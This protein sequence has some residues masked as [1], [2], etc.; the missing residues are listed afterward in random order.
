MN[1]LHVQAL[2]AAKRFKKAEA[3]L[4]DIFQKIED[5]KVFRKMGYSSLF[6][7]GV[8][9]L[10]L[11]EANTYA[12]IQ[13]ARK[14]RDVPALKSARRDGSLS[15]SKAKKIVS[16]I[17]SENQEDWLMKAQSLSK[18]LLEKEVARVNPK[19]AVQESSKYVTECR[20]ELKLGISEELLKNLKRVQDIESQRTR[21]SA[22]LEDA[23]REMTELYLERNDP[24]RKAERARPQLVP[25][26]VEGEGRKRVPAVLKHAIQF[27]DEGQC[28]HLNPDGSRCTQTRWL[29]TH[30]LKP[31]SMGGTNSIS[32]L[33]TLCFHHHRLRHDV[34]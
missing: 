32:N 9:A 26:P 7:Y 8:K 1:P 21:K 25:G 6:D 28:T 33:T 11:S 18:N 27:R 14:S 34:S 10:R 4:I 12:F 17:T 13:V 19:T 29:E 5:A 24:V 15:V 16:V 22:S 30:H 2:E 20:L 3:D 23:L 31:V